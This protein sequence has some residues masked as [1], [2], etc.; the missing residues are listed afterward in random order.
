MFWHFM[1]GETL[2]FNIPLSVLEIQEG[3]QYGRLN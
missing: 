3:V 2:L 1:K